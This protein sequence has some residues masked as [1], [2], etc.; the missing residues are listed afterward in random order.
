MARKTGGNPR[1]ERAR[2]RERSGTNPSEPAVDGQ[3]TAATT[4]SRPTSRRGAKVAEI[5][6][7]DIIRDAAGQAYGSALPGEAAMMARYGVSRGSLREALR[8]LELQGLIMMKPGPGGG[9]ILLGANAESLGRMQSLHFHLLGARYGDVADARLVL[10]PQLARM[11]AQRQDRDALRPLEEFVTAKPDFDVDNDPEYA[12]KAQGFHRLVAS[13]S[14]NP[15][16]DMVASA[17]QE[18]TL[19]RVRNSVLEGEDRRRAIDDHLQIARAIL[20]GNGPKAEL[21]MNDHMFHYRAGYARREF[22]QETV[23]WY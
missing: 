23:D 4:S 6:A 21:L 19:S 17:L 13:L 20:D 5:V 1:G 22:S 7:R 2:P 3:P 16:L 8:L 15:V 11:V 18:I 9:P 10:E 12:A 14:G